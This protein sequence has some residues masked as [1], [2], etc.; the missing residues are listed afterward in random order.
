MSAKSNREIAS[1]GGTGDVITRPAP[2]AVTLATGVPSII[3]QRLYVQQ[4]VYLIQ[5][6]V[7]FTAP[8]A[9][10]TIGKL[11]LTNTNEIG[12]I[13]N[14]TLIANSTAGSTAYP[15]GSLNFVATG[16]LVATTTG[17]NE[18]ISSLTW[19]GAGTA[20]TASAVINAIKVV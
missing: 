9:T 19:T 4:G 6:N 18:L 1:I 11:V 16:T 5:V 13:Q 15:A 20:P 10:T 2:P 14:F 7:T 3:S 8:D 12:S 17:T